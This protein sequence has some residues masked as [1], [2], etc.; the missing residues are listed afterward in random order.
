[1]DYPSRKPYNPQETEG[2][3][4]TIDDIFDRRVIDRKKISEYGF[5]QNGNLLVLHKALSSGNLEILVS[6]DEDDRVTAKIIDTDF[7]EEYIGLKT[8]GRSGAYAGLVRE[9]C[10]GILE[11]IA[12]HC[13]YR[14]YFH[15]DQANR[16]CA[17]IT[18]TYGCVPRF[19]WPRLPGYGI[20]ESEGAAFASIINVDRVSGDRNSNSVEELNIKEGKEEGIFPPFYKAMKGWVAVPLDDRM[21]DDELE[22]L[23]AE[24]YQGVHRRNAWIVP[25]N[26]SRYDIIKHFALQNTVIWKQVAG[27]HVGDTVY[28]YLAAPYSS[29]MYRC[30]VVEINIPK[31][32]D[33]SR[34]AKG[35]ML[36]LEEAYGKGRYPFSLLKEHGINF[37][38]G[39][40]KVPDALLQIL[41]GKKQPS[42]GA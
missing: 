17:W 35:M 34:V 41:Q 9:E 15:T 31:P 26:N 10:T 24:S 42:L 14:L 25:A 30:K 22:K 27:A 13:S 19:P 18:E 29:I 38:R 7:G 36:E 2:A 20:F 16:I 21:A 5:R 37:Y 11:D 12:R 1:M 33:D 4:M 32:F 8:I 23:I 28:L 6:I 39:K 40:R 3:T